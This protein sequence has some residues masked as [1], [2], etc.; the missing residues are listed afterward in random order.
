MSIWFGERAQISF[1]EIL[2]ARD[3]RQLAAEVRNAI[4]TAESS[5][6]VT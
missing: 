1:N 3:T 5:H 4:Q 6:A 2:D